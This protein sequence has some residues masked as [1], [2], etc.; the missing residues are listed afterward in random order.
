MCRRSTP[1]VDILLRARLEW[2]LSQAILEQEK[3]WRPHFDDPLC[4]VWRTHYCVP[5]PQSW[6]RVALRSHEC[7]RGTQE[8][9]RHSRKNGAA[10]HLRRERKRSQALQSGLTKPNYLLGP[11]QFERVIE[12]AHGISPAPQPFQQQPRPLRQP[13]ILHSRPSGIHHRFESTDLAAQIRR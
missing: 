9:V 3:N 6:G 11:P 8:C 1:I 7:E 4:G 13:P 10:G 2:V 12:R 5:R